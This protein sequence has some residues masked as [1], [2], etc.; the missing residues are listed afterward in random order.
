MSVQRGLPL[1]GGV[2]V[3]VIGTGSL[4]KEHVR[5]YAELAAARQVEFVGVYDA[6]AETA[7]R[8]AEKHGVRAFGSVAE[9]AAASDAASIVTPTTTHFELAKTLLEQG[10]HVLVEKPMTDSAARAAELVAACPGDELCAA[11]GARRALQPGVQVPGDGGHRAALHRD[12]SPLALT[13]R[14][15]RTSASCST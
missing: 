14:A 7:R 12:A 10:R 2:K 4:G 11:S 3:S 13:R 6:V 5:I 9:A 1:P 15:A 8:L